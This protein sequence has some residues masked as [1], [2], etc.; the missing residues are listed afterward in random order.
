MQHHPVL[1]RVEADDQVGF[2]RG[3][4]DEHVLVSFDGS[5][6]FVDEFH[7]TGS[8]ELWAVGDASWCPALV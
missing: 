8:E 5:V 1:A 3:S 7:S 6:E 2:D 4:F